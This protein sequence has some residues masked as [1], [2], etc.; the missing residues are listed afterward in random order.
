[1]DGSQSAAARACG[2]TLEKGVDCWRFSPAV[3]EL[4]PPSGQFATLKMDSE[5][6][7]ACGLR[8]NGNA[9]CWTSS[10]LLPDSPVTAPISTFVDIAVGVDHV[11]GL[12]SDGSVTR[13]GADETA[14]ADAA[15]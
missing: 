13:C 15:S 8:F 9:I 11:C 10:V 5:G 14:D 6:A 3:A 7:Y 1:M 2:L 12:C 4:L